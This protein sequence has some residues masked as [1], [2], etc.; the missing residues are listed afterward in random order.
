MRGG[1]NVRGRGRSGEK[2]VYKRGISGCDECDK[3]GNVGEGN[4]RGGICEGDV[5]EGGVEIK[6][7]EKRH[8]L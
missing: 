3:G 6:E 4:V 8:Y 1:I 5:R 7:T 2:G